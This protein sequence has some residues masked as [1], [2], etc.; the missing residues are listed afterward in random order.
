VIRVGTKLVDVYEKTGRLGLMMFMI[1]EITW[2][3]Q[4]EELVKVERKTNIRY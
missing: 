2:T 3:N 4:D 1:N